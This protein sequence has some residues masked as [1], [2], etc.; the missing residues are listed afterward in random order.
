MRRGRELGCGSL[1]MMGRSGLW[2]S[3][4][5]QRFRRAN[6]ANAGA[7]RRIQWTDI[8]RRPCGNALKREDVPAP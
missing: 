6:W 4:N 5:P 3:L 8:G 7:T 1:R 2:A